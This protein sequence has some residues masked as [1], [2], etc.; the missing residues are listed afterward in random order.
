M[1]GQLRGQWL[2]RVPYGW[3]WRLQ[4]LRRDAIVAGR[5]P[6]A[7]WLLEHDPVITT[8]RRAV[9]DL[10]AEAVL[11][12]KGVSLFRAE[13]GGLAT[14]HG[15]GQLVGYLLLDIARHGHKVRT[16][17][18]AVEQG[19]IDWLRARGVGAHRREGYPGVWVGREKICA[20][21]FHFRH[22]VSMHGFALNLCPN[23]GGFAL[24]TPCGIVDG[25]VTSLA[26]VGGGVLA[27]WEAA[28]SVAEAV[29]AACVDTTQSWHYAN[30]GTGT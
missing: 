21:G 14:W 16:F 30:R 27:P 29:I 9:D 8:G 18:C 5:A 25:G 28:E 26:L 1:S 10:P 15:P 11:H 6:E 24:I 2:G 19:I 20:V 7:F 13:R 4:H 12:L 17:V 3:A 22:G 23:L